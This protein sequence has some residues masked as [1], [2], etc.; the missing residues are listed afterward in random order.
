M[1][2]T[3]TDRAMDHLDELEAQ[4]IYVFREAYRS[5][6][7]LAMLWSIGKDST[8][9][10]WMARRAFL[11]RVPFPLLHIDTTFKFPEMYTFRDHWAKAWGL[12]LI[13]GCNEQAVAEGISYETHDA[14]EI[15]HQMKTVALQ[16]TLDEYGFQGLFLG[17][18]RDEEGSRAKERVFSP[19]DRNF[20]W[21]Y[22]DQPPEFWDQ[23]NTSFGDGA[24]VRIHPILHWT[25]IDIWR[26]IRREGIPT[27]SLYFA[28]HGRRYRSLG[29]Q[30]VT[31]PIESDADTIDKIIDELQTTK[32]PERSG[33]TMD[34]S[35]SYAMQKLRAMGYM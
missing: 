13:V 8:A 14:F 3:V 11:G 7:N 23:F 17:I 31:K 22:K 34:S 30:Q 4:T 25:E 35:R 2:R 5:F 21:H 12:N 9:S 18:R 28:Q 29:D 33:R 1:R 15:A 6:D 26:Y 16:Q 10:L 32:T 27:C 24:H 19:R 20:E